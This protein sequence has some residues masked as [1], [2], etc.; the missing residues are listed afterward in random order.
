[1]AETYTLQDWIVSIAMHDQAFRE[2]L[3]Q[4]PKE[5]LERELG[6]SFPEEVEIEMHEDTPTIIHLVLPLKPKTGSL[7]EVSYADLQDS[8]EAQDEPST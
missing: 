2:E 4:N 1:M 5:T 7:M 8:S 6:I 3:M